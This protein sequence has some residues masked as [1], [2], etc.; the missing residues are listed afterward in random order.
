MGVLAFPVETP[1]QPLSNIANATAE[2]REMNLKRINPGPNSRRSDA[3]A[4]ADVGLRGQSAAK[5][6]FPNHV[7]QP[8]VGTGTIA[9]QGEGSSPRFLWLIH[10]P[11]EIAFA[12]D[13]YGKL[14]HLSVSCCWFSDAGEA[15]LRQA[16]IMLQFSR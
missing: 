12:Y 16:W 11:H 9:V 10:S 5:K 2:T 15:R 6:G 1:P 7:G 8:H 4:R 13:N 14:A 3:L